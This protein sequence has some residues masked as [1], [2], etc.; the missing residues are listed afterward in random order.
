M[1]FDTW[2]STGGSYLAPGSMAGVGHT[3]EEQGRSY[4]GG[5]W[6]WAYRKVGGATIVLL[7]ND[8]DKSD[9]SLRMS[10]QKALDAA[11]G[12]AIDREWNRPRDV[13]QSP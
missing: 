13:A 10:I 4:G 1:R 12:S 6:A 5:G 9:K 11:I 3:R 2:L 8:G 7:L